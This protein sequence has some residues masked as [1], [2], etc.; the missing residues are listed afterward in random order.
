[1]CI[2]TAFLLIANSCI[3]CY[4]LIDNCVICEN[5]SSCL[6]CLDNYYL[7]DGQCI[8]G[9]GGMDTWAIVLI[10]LSVVGIFGA[11]RKFYLI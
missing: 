10:V 3:M 8:R 6:R 2:S 11:L 7:Y 1:M 9:G 5:T 4:S